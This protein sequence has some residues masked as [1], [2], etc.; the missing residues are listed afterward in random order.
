MLSASY[1]DGK[2]TVSVTQAEDGDERVPGYHV[3]VK[4]ADGVIHR[5]FGFCSGYYLADMP[6]VAE[7]TVD[8]EAPAGEYT[9]VCR[10]YSFFDKVSDAICTTVVV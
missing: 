9:V 2:L 8:F 6:P 7:Y 3:A 5:Q 10:A 4:D 1:A